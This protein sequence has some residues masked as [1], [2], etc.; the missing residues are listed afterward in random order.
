MAIP[1]PRPLCRAV[2]WRE[3][4]G[5]P[6]VLASLANYLLMIPEVGKEPASEG[7][8]GLS[9][10]RAAGRPGAGG[11]GRGGVLKNEPDNEAARNKQTN[12]QAFRISHSGLV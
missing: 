3:G 12:S 11:R 7:E 8:S 6:L 2:Q 1:T 4:V 5:S 9:F 10:R